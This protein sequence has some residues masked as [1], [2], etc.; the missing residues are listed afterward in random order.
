MGIQSL[1]DSFLK[2][3]HQNNPIYTEGGWIQD[4]PW[5]IKQAADPQKIQDFERL[6]YIIPEDLKYLLSVTDG[7]FC[8]S[9]DQMI[10][11][12]DT[13]MEV[14]SINEELKPGIYEFACFLDERLCI[15]SSKI[16]TGNY[17]FY[18]GDDH[19]KGCL[20]GYGIETLIDR[21]IASN[22]NP[23]WRWVCTENDVIDYLRE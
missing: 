16:E 15:D 5:H 1:L 22:F 12:I 9:V 14:A 23:F 21:L 4:N 7:V 19:T 10:Y 2:I 18:I 13:L 6:G 8:G 3:A 17:I 20:L 11:D